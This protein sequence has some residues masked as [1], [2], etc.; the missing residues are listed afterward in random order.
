MVRAKEEGLKFKRVNI[1]IEP[2]LHQT[3]TNKAGDIRVPL[4]SVIADLLSLWI[5]DKIDL[6]GIKPDEQTSIHTDKH[7]YTPDINQMINDAI[8]PL[9]RK[10]ADLEQTS[11]HT[12]THHSQ[13]PGI[14]VSGVTP[15]DVSPA[16]E[17][18]NTPTPVMAKTKVSGRSYF[19]GDT[20]GF[21]TGFEKWLKDN[22]YSQGQFKQAY[23]F[24]I[25]AMSKWKKGTRPL[26]LDKHELI[27]DIMS[28]KINSP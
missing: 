26:P 28:G 21:I 9:L 22:R 23:G 1:T 14:D 19:E 20:Q 17:G 18:E 5:D 7:Q 16:H 8:T 24:D 27:A 13:K 6:N 15:M 11:I 2:G 10:I 12:D 4:S 25:T 3:A